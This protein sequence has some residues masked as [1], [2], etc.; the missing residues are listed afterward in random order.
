MQRYLSTLYKIVFFLSIFQF[1]CAYAAGL[2]D[3]T[4]GSIID[5]S[6][7]SAEQLLASTEMVADRQIAHSAN[8]MLV[9]TKELEVA[10]SGQLDK[11]LDEFDDA[12][13]SAFQEV[14]I[15]RQTIDGAPDRISGIFDDVTLDVEQILGGTL[16]ANYPMW[17]KRI[18]GFNQLYQANSDYSFK[19][20]GSGFGGGE[21][22]I[23][24]IR[25]G[26][27]NVTNELNFNYN[28]HNVSV[29][30]PKE[31]LDP[32]FDLEGSIV[33][34]KINSV[35]I[36][37]T[38]QRP[39]KKKWWQF[40]SQSRTETLNHSFHLY[41]I[42]PYAGS[43][44]Y[45]AFVEEFEWTNAG[46][47]DFVHQTRQNSCGGDCDNDDQGNWQISQHGAPSSQSS[48]VAQ[49]QRTP[50]RENDERLRMPTYSGDTSHHRNMSASLSQN[51]A[52]LNFSIGSWGNS[53]PITVSAIKEIYVKKPMPTEL[54]QEF[55]D[56]EFGKT[57]QLR[58]PKGSVLSTYEFDPIG[59]APLSSGELKKNTRN[60][61]IEVTSH[62]SVGELK[63]VNIRI[64]NPGEYPIPTP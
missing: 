11:A 17:V 48:C 32:F 1:Q 7:A 52:C 12:T 43:L 16:F 50:P 21:V 49:K 53:R 56:V 4:I 59:T 6:R 40:F 15:L 26:D 63:I 57:Y 61:A 62:S 55:L 22:K 46:T 9:I 64:P 39:Q 54:T 44:K 35:P 58:F 3:E 27:V 18:S 31:T 23:S 19:V 24:D 42:P 38:L 37:I 47:L 51:S 2:G 34:R 14:D 28:G 13:Y 10:F 41:L 8:E 29:N 60:Y 45:K 20:T 36:S 30:I 33:D 25:L 5:K